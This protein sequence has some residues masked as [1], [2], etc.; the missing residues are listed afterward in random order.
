MRI[1]EEHRTQTILALFHVGTILVGSIGI[2]LILKR[3]GYT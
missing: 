3:F 1:L 2:G